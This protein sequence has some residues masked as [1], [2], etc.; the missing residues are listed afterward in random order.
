MPAG[1]RLD[2]LVALP[3]TQ[4]FGMAA[5]SGL[6]HVV[7]GKVLFGVPMIL[8]FLH[9]NFVEGT[10]TPRMGRSRGRGGPHRRGDNGVLDVVHGDAAVAGQNSCATQ[11]DRALCHRV[12]AKR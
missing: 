10:L 3:R 9:L 1:V 8:L 12:V 5:K 7:I 2:T 4:R 11:V 6:G